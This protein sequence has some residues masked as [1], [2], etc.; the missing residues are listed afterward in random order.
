MTL[1]REIDE[2]ASWALLDHA[3]ACG[4]RLFDTA[5]AYG[6]G[7]SESILGRWLASRCPRGITI[8]TKIL[9]PYDLSLI[10]I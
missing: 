6:Q 5:V 10:H 3:L 2:A 7:A 8:A 1:G 9:P 4:V